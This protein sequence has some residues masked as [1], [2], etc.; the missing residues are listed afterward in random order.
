MTC[1]KE[2]KTYFDRRGSW[3]LDDVFKSSKIPPE[4]I[5]PIPRRL[6][7][8]ATADRGGLTAAALYLGRPLAGPAAADKFGQDLAAAVARSDSGIPSRRR[9]RLT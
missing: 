1:Y 3:P 9:V 7:L 2:R 5:S 4:E 8:P 6:P